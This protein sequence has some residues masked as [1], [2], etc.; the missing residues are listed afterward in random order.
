M[1]LLFLSDWA[2]TW[3]AVKEHFEN[4]FKHIVFCLCTLETEAQ[5]VNVWTRRVLLR[6]LRVLSELFIWFIFFP[7]IK[8]NE[9]DTVEAAFVK[10][11][12]LSSQSVSF[13]WKAQRYFLFFSSGARSS[14]NKNNRKQKDDETIELMSVTWQHDRVMHS[15]WAAEN[16]FVENC[17]FPHV[18]MN[19]KIALIRLFLTHQ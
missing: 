10:T 9:V 16:T 3:W 13:P 5:P 18:L 4:I 6:P 15:R 19:T 8:K 1:R 2:A 7:F 14:G 17:T 11:A 12:I